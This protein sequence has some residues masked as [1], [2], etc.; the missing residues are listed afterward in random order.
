M[1]EKTFGTVPA[2]VQKTV[3]THEWIYCS[4]ERVKSGLA[5]TNHPC[6]MC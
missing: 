5:G 1:I 6:P 2:N 4:N 3:S